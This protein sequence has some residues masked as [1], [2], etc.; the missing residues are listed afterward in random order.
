MSSFLP[1]LKIGVTSAFLQ[2]KTL[3]TATMNDQRLLR[4]ALQWY[5]PAISILV[6]TSHQG[7]WTY[8]CPVC[9][10]SLTESTFSKATSS[11]LQ[12]FS[13]DSGTWD[14]WK[15]VL[16]LK[17]VARKEFSTSAFPVSHVMRSTTVFSNVPMFSLDFLLSP[18]YI[19]KTSLMSLIS[20]DR[21]NCI[22]ALAFLVSTLCA[23][24][25]SLYSSWAICPC[26]YP[27]YISCWCLCLARN[28]MFIHN[29]CCI[30]AP[31]RME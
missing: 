12:P 10:C 23:W 1:F 21:L 13:L 30:L 22:W 18:V 8:S 17:T 16:L 14:S 29:T 31:A 5:L 28:S 7:S 26:F 15:P 9:K 6:N 25:M 19:Q 2:S 4:V 3:L 20:L 11:L 27:L 24:T